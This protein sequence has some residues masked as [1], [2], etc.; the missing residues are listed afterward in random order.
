MKT[1]IILIIC[2]SIRVNA[3]DATF[4]SLDDRTQKYVSNSIAHAI[5]D[6]CIA[7]IHSRSDEWLREDML[8]N[9]RARI[10]LGLQKCRLVT[11]LK[12]TSRIASYG[13]CYLYVPRSQAAGQP[14]VFYENEIPIPYQPFVGIGDDITRLVLLRKQTTLLKDRVLSAYKYQRRLETIT[15][16]AVDLDENDFINKYGLGNVFSNHV[17]QVIEGCVFRAECYVP[18][19]P[20]THLINLNR[21][22]LE[23]SRSKV[24]VPGDLLSLT[25]REVS[26]IVFLAYQLE[27]EGGIIRYEEALRKN[28]NLLLPIPDANVETHLGR[29]VLKKISEISVANGEREIVSGAF[30][31]GR[32]G[33]EK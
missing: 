29:M 1:V 23:Q 24:H 8:L 16:D 32:Q 21:G 15:T 22:N 25:R 18:E 17:F 26:E 10:V 31:G 13:E 4:G 33:T 27:G 30:S 5:R 20:D 19:L 11:M 12:G 3:A 9:N 14:Y 6:S 2:L 7:I 28:V